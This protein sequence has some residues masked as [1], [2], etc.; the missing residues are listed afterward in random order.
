[1]TLSL[2]TRQAPPSNPM[3]WRKALVTTAI[4]AVVWIAAYYFIE[5]GYLTF[6]QN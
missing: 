2:A 4:S 1:M 6:R 3:L 5:S